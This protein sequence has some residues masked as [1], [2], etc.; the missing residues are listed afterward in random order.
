MTFNFFVSLHSEKKLSKL[1]IN[2]NEMTSKQKGILISY[3][4]GLLPTILFTIYYCVFCV[5]NIEFGT[6]MFIF[7]YLH[8]TLGLLVSFLIA[9]GIGGRN[10]VIDIQKQ[11]SLLKTSFNYSLTIN[12]IIWAVFIILTIIFRV[13]VKYGSWSLLILPIFAFVFCTAI[14]TFTIGLLICYV[15]KKIITNKQINESTNQQ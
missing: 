12:T 11:K 15:I 8:G 7:L 3:L 1:T 10:A 6:T 13:C 2:K 14:T 9:L 5:K 4:I